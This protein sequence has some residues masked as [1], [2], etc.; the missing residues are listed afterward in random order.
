VIGTLSVL[1]HNKSIDLRLSMP[2]RPPF[3]WQFI[4]SDNLRLK[5]VLLNLTDNAVKYCNSG[6]VQVN[7]VPVGYFFNDNVP[8]DRELAPNNSMKPPFQTIHELLPFIQKEDF[9]YMGVAKHKILTEKQQPYAVKLRFEVIDTGIGKRGN[10]I[11][12]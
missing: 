2:M 10:L 6:H 1:A 5:K 8:S 12:K 4:Y 11:N 3:P 9:V 7:V